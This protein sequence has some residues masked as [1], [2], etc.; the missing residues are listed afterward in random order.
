MTFRSSLSSSKYPTY[1]PSI[2]TPE[3]FAAL[4]AA[5]KRSSPM[6]WLC[7]KEAVLKN[8]MEKRSVK[9]VS[10]NLFGPTMCSLLTGWAIVDCRIV[11]QTGEFCS[12]LSHA[13]RRSP[14]R[15]I[16]A[17]SRHKHA[18]SGVP[19]SSLLLSGQRAARYIPHVSP[20]EE[21]WSG[22][23]RCALLGEQMVK[24][25]SAAPAHHYGQRRGDGQE[26]IFNPLAFLIAGPVHEEAELLVDHGDGCHHIA[27]DAEGGNASEESKDEAQPAEELGGDGEKRERRGNAHL[28]GEKTHGGA[29]TITAKPTQHFLRAVS[30][31]DNSQRDSKNRCRPITLRPHQVAKHNRF[32]LSVV[33]LRCRLCMGLILGSRLPL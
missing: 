6:T 20:G 7:A 18:K 15:W 32:L 29:E 1:C 11:A 25:E 28:M 33:M 23:L 21:R 31:K 14:A 17:G 10:L 8:R 22:G 19:P 9:P 4:E 24:G 5:M 12:T 13:L 16:D 3:V 30:K 26:V 27:E 2:H